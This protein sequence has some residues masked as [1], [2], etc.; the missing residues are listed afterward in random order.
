MTP[1]QWKRIVG[2]EIKRERGRR[3]IRSIAD[4]A[5]VSEG[6]W[7]SVESGA[8]RPAKGVVKTVNPKPSTRA[9][10]ADAL[11][12]TPD[13]IDRLLLGED[14]MPKLATVESGPPV[15]RA[16]MRHITSTV[17]D[18]GSRLSEL[19]HLV[20]EMQEQ[21][22]EKDENVAHQFQAMNDRVGRAVDD[23]QR[24]VEALERRQ[25]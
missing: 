10:I 6:L 23:L 3:S 19:E 4:K 15:T 5:G 12:W 8:H 14:P 11:G 7:R 1:E 22:A 16:E 25:A 17:V 18:H 13:S 2:D 21:R 9:L 24:R 20:V